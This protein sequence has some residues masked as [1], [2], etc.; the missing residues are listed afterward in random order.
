[1]LEIYSSNTWGEF[2][3]LKKCKCNKINLISVRLLKI[4]CLNII[5]TL[6]FRLFS[7]FKNICKNKQKEKHYKEV[8]E[9]ET[10]CKNCVLKSYIIIDKE[11]NKKRFRFGKYKN[12]KE[13]I[14][15][16]HPIANID[17]I[18]DI[19]YNEKKVLNYKLNNFYFFPFVRKFFFILKN[20]DY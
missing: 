7:S 15:V 9:I 19:F 18:K 2:V 14:D 10:F 8:I 16:C 13:I 11:N 5:N 12:I 1:M 3:P 20:T 4:P 17:I 6:V